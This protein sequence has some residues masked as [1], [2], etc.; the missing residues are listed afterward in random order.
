MTEVYSKHGGWVVQAPNYINN[1]MN[2][3]AHYANKNHPAHACITDKNTIAGVMAICKDLQDKKE[4][5]E[6][7]ADRITELEEALTRVGYWG[8]DEQLSDEE[9]VICTTNHNEGKNCIDCEFW[10]V[11]NCSVAEIAKQ[12]LAKGKNYAE[13]GRYK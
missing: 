8:C 12:V 4:L 11:D 3:F 13:D 10:Y 5:I 2:M 9:A 1:H 6:E 7:M